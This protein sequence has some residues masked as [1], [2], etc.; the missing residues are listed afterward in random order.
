[1]QNQLNEKNTSDYTPL[2]NSPN[3]IEPPLRRPYPSF[4]E[5]IKKI[6]EQHYKQDKKTFAKKCNIGLPV[7]E[8][9]E[10]PYYKKNIPEESYARIMAALERDGI[11]LKAWGY[12]NKTEREALK[13]KLP[14]THNENNSTVKWPSGDGP[15]HTELDLRNSTIESLNP[16]YT[17]SSQESVQNTT[18]GNVAHDLPETKK[19]TELSSGS[20]E[21][22]SSET[23]THDTPIEAGYT[24]KSPG[25]ADK[26]D[27]MSRIS[28]V[29]TSN[30]VDW[31]KIRLRRITWA[32]KILCKKTT[33]RELVEKIK[34]TVDFKK[35]G[36]KS[37]S[38]SD[39]SMVFRN[40]YSS[41]TLFLGK[42]NT[43][44]KI[45]CPSNV[46]ERKAKL[47]EDFAKGQFD[48]D[49]YVGLYTEEKIKREDAPTENI[50]SEK[51]PPLA[52]YR[53]KFK[54]GE[55]VV[56]HKECDRIEIAVVPKEIREIK[57]NEEGF[58]YSF[59][60]NSDDWIPEYNI[61]SI[62]GYIAL[63]QKKLNELRNQKE[64]ANG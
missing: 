56:F 5:T 62:D 36:V 44:L 37:V 28:F 7:L 50:S 26:A 23:K 38:Q 59:E 31:E 10:N 33:Q 55:K 22:E 12:Y 1:M 17:K 42:I 53:A 25:V 2:N 34:T 52:L 27:K 58:F 30:G 61:F 49:A 60:K 6:R 16:D 51:Q 39:I 46:D 54:L 9:L 32:Y 18:E 29:N 21:T 15:R 47:L 14:K 41:K 48:K 20:S 3:N 4:G 63:A 19:H 57:I 40:F 8:N 11:S 13:V 45:K 64:V 43:D 35:A 24:M